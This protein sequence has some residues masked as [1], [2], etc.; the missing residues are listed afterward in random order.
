MSPLLS[1]KSQASCLLKHPLL[2]KRLF[3]PTRICDDSS[4][5]SW[6]ESPSTLYVFIDHEKKCCFRRDF[7]VALGMREIGA[8][9]RLLLET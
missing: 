1:G 7:S 6:I 5:V 8:Q 2:N 4:T 9:P 3:R